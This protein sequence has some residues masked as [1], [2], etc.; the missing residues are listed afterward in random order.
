MTK[1]RLFFIFYYSISLLCKSTFPEW[2][3]NTI[4]I[5]VGP[6]FTETSRVRFLFVFSSLSSGVDSFPPRVKDRRPLI[7][8]R[9]TWWRKVNIRLRRLS[10]GNKS[11][12]T[13]SSCLNKHKCL[14]S[15]K[16]EVWS[17]W[18]LSL[19]PTHGTTKRV[20]QQ[21][22]LVRHHACLRHWW[23]DRLVSSF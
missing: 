5:T 23:W 1:S 14:R 22:T 4:I 2:L 15:R 6:L 13:I 17:G 21:I 3:N 10:A 16:L 7:S 18:E 20:V 12:T 8:A 19:L 11:A 9:N